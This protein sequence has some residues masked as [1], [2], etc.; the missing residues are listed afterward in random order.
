MKPARTAKGRKAVDTVDELD[1]LSAAVEG[2]RRLAEEWQGSGNPELDRALQA[3]DAILR[4]VRNRM[5]AVM[6]ELDPRG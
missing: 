6:D 4:L 1:V 5:R 2:A 3:V